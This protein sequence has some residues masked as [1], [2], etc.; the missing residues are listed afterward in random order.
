MENNEH[1]A[2][3]DRIT[4]EILARIKEIGGNDA[5][6]VGTG[7]L[8][9]PQII[10][11]SL[12]RPL[13]NPPEKIEAGSLYIDAE[14]L[15]PEL[16]A[17][18]KGD[19]AQEGVLASLSKEAIDRRDFMRMFSST[20]FLGASAVACV[21]R[22]EEHA[23]PFVNQPVD[24][25]P[26]RATYFATTCGE[27]PSA[28]RVMV[29]T[30]EGRPVK[31]EGD[32]L[33][34]ISQGALCSVG[35]STL[36]ELYHPE[37][38]KHPMIRRGQRLD[39]TTWG[40]V[41]EVLATKIKDKSKIAIISTGS[42]GNDDLFYKEFLANL[43]SNAT[44]HYKF[45]A[46]SLWAEVS[47][48]HELAFGVSAIPRPDLPNSKVI[49]GFGAG[50]LDDGLY[51]T[52]MN[53]GFAAGHGFNSMTGSRGEFIQFESFLS[54]TGAKADKRYVIPAGSE[55]GALVLLIQHLY[56]K[57]GSKTDAAVKAQA[58]ELLRNHSSWLASA[59]QTLA[60]SAD[61]MDAL[62]DKLLNAPS[63][64]FAGSTATMDDQGTALQLA[65]IIANQMIGA[66]GKTLFLDSAWF[67]PPV[68]AGDMQRFLNDAA[69]LD[70]VFVINSN[71][72]FTV[73]AAFG[74][75]EALQ[76]IDTVVSIQSFPC[77]TDN[78]A[79][80]VL[81]GHHYL[82][83]WG[84]AQPAA[85]YWNIR[86]PAV[87]P[88]SNSQQAE[89]ILLWLSAQMG[90]P[91]G[92]KDYRAFLDKQWKRLQS[93]FG[94]G[95]EMNYDFFIKSV[96]R[97][98]GLG[99]PENQKV[100]GLRAIASLIKVKAIDP[101]AFS[102]MLPLH[103]HLQE[104]R[105][106]TRPIL[107]ETPH[108]LTTVVWDSYILMSPQKAMQMRI[109]RNDVVKIS[110]AS[111]S[112]E[113][114]VY[115]MPG[116]HPSAIVFYR[117]NGREN[118]ISKV[119]DGFGINPL[120]LV[121]KAFDPIGAEPVTASIPVTLEKTGKR[122]SLAATQKQSDIGNRFD[123]VRSIPLS[124]A[125]SN[126]MRSKDLDEVPDLYPKLP[127][128]NHRWG[129]SI[130]LDKCTGCGACQVACSTENNVPQVGRE[131]ILMGREMY[132][133][134]IDRYFT[135]PM[136]NPQTFFQ[137]MPC[138]HC[139]HAPCEAV[140]PVFATSHDPEGVN[141]MTYNR[142]VGTRYCANACPYKVRRFNWWT[143]KW[144]AIGERLV[145]RN[146]RA[147]N[148]DV[149]I[150]TR[151]V[152]EKCNFCYQRIRE[153]KHRAAASTTGNK[154]VYVQMACEQT[155]ASDAITFGDLFLKGQPAARAR[156]DNRAYLALGGKP[157]D[158]EYGLKTL[159]NVSYLM[160]VVVDQGAEAPDQ[161]G[162]EH[163]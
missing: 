24:M 62:A 117:G 161:N 156:A 138:Q 13:E 111:G 148:P 38:R 140:C 135:G 150:R 1:I 64:V 93:I 155:C 106:A 8:E 23:L 107:Q 74:F 121:A 100:G 80:F 149:T 105:G 27:C 51:H 30:R 32:P 145:D 152:M 157:E 128:A 146:P 53:K 72:A 76:K 112:I 87:R 124:E 123:I 49:A 103:P 37:R 114:P 33:D 162:Y 81:N 55:L 144:N 12:S 79:H 137:P 6:E 97:R 3:S 163:G 119:S 136:E 46:K 52:F 26:G 63:I 134:R 159:P 60:V 77:E 95:A 54:P 36:Q 120:V 101:D 2:E 132:W 25:V 84:D 78:H 20:A 129:M 7:Q 4:D 11:A 109:K 160:K 28:C 88:L 34:A 31:L 44:R 147:L 57:A 131:Q 118:G 102:L 104:G 21:R 14:E 91:M 66:Y 40:D 17:H 61:D 141:A 96:L 68:Q 142:C 86:Q 158:G 151:G 65:A 130:D 143:H 59:Y 39:E 5:D 29:K 98:G 139:N 133:L 110:T 92:Y 69:D 70:A 47:K 48:A 89:D 83:S 113:V 42:T 153:A 22:P 35:Q 85:G 125:V 41:Y 82:E 75:K 43:G 90:K 15:A 122:Y 58:A 9:N 127:S 154:N 94:Q 45:E 126:R 73:P 116:T 19:D 50:F 115:P 18:R 16:G 67:L 71:P 99:K 56:N 10:V 108:A